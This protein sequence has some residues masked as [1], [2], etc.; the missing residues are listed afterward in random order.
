MKRRPAAQEE[1]QRAAQA[2]D[3]C[4]D[5][6]ALCIADLLGRDELGRAQH[7]AGRASA[8]P[9]AIRDRPET[10]RLRAEHPLLT[11]GLGQAEVEYLDDRPAP[12][13]GEHEV[14]RLDVAVHQPGLK[15]VLQ[16]QRRLMDERAGVGDRHRALGA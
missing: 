10:S 3:V 16:A 9:P 14:A 15:S 6:G 1:V 5:V 7:L 11:P 8:S 4:A 12:F 13:V 2:I